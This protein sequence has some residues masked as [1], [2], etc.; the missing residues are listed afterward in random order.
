MAKMKTT[1]EDLHHDEDGHGHVVRGGPDMTDFGA[2]E[3]NDFS[4]DPYAGLG[5]TWG[6][7]EIADLDRVI[8]QI[9]SGRSQKVTAN[10]T[11]TFT[12]L[13]EGDGLIGVYNNPNYGFR[14]GDGLAAFSDAQKAEA[15]DSIE[16]WDDLISADIVETKGRGADIQFANSTDPA[17]AYAYYPNEK[18]GYKYFGDVFVAD[19][20]VNWSNAW[21]NFGGY[22]ATTLVHELGHALGLSHPGAYNGAGATT[23]ANQ[24]EY[25]Q[26]S[27]QYTIMSYWGLENT[28]LN[29]LNVDWSTGFYNN[30]QTPLVHDILT[31]QT[32]YGADPTTRAGDTVYGWNSTAG[33]EVYD[34]SVNL[35]PY[36]SIYDAGGN[37]TID[38]SGAG[39]SVY[40][41][42]NEGAFSSGAAAI[43]D[44]DVINANREYIRSTGYEEQT[45]STL[46]DV[47]DTTPAFWSSTY[48]PYYEDVLR[49]DTALATGVS[50]D[51]LYTTAVDNLS[52][53]YGTIIENAIGSTE[54]DY[55]V[56]NQVVNV[57]DGGAGDDVLDGGIGADM[58]I[59]GEGA[60]TFMFTNF[61]EGDTIADFETGTDMIDLTA[62]GFTSYAETDTFSGTAGELIYANGVLM[63]DYDG[64]GVADIVINVQGDA[65]DMGDLLL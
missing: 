19:P 8:D 43:P 3:P 16:L 63:G 53:A 22:G 25:A 46:T 31:I 20:D 52:I 56:G 37:D 45:G 11:I 9:D 42:L 2:M 47:F 28:S 29:Q 48:Q 14:A 49:D 23:Y 51:G 54:R 57:L 40:I 39:V 4:L 58:L 33:N 61:D 55:L 36:L 1:N 26:D 17:Q 60:D 32:K 21:L 34:F 30:P 38:M 5:V 35:F 24:A 44:A 7:K 15:R 12:F 27:E 65:V 13:D 64:D 59:G 18:G 6:G 50:V 41:N 62:F 10:N